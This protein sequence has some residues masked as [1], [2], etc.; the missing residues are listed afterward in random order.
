MQIEGNERRMTHSD[1]H[2]IIVPGPV[3]ETHGIVG[4]GFWQVISARPGLSLSVF[5]AINHHIEGDVVHTTPCI[6]LI[7]LFAA[8]GESWMIDPQGRRSEVVPLRPGRL[9]FTYAPET[10]GGINEVPAGTRMRGIDIRLSIDLWNRI[11][12]SIPPCRFDADHAHHTAICG[13]SWV[14]ILPVSPEQ[15]L[16]AQQI[17]DAALTQNEDLIV[18]ARCL[19]LVNTTLKTLAAAPAARSA[20]ARDKQAV[21]TVLQC[22]HDALE[23]D[24]SVAELAAEAGISTKRLKRIFP[25]HT[26]LPVYKYLQ[27]ARLSGAKRLLTEGSNRVTDVAL[28]VGYSSLSHFSALFR[29]R[30]GMSP[31]QFANLS[32][33]SRQQDQRPRQKQ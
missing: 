26:G 17:Y 15:R 1:A 30:F 5:D 28:T 25:A 10:T 33:W 4:E 11:T 12:G 19:E 9:Y 7:Y 13:A 24:W 31:S 20:L 14:G 18:E 6:S 32:Y 16:A 22:M 8:R 27:E 21:Q 29:R 2:E 3:S 23:R